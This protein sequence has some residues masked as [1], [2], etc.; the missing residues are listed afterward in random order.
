MKNEKELV[1]V[2]QS[3]PVRHEGTVAEIVAR[4]TKI[5]EAMERV[6]KVGIDYGTIPG[7]DKPSL[8]KAGAEKIANL[9]CFALIPQVDDMSTNEERR[10]RVRVEVMHQV[11]HELLG[12]GIGEASTNEE[13]YKWRRALCKEEFEGSDP[14]RRRVKWARNRRTG[15]MEQIHQIRTEPSDL[16]NTVL[17]MAKKRGVVDAI[18]TTTAAS[19]IFTQDVEDMPA[20]YIDT[21]VAPSQPAPQRK[22]P[23]PDVQMPTNPVHSNIHLI[24]GCISDYIPAKGKGPVTIKLEG[25]DDYFKTFSHEVAETLKEHGTKGDTIEIAYHVEKQG[26]WT[27]CM[28]DEVTAMQEEDQLA[29]ET[30]K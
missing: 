12:C 19:D 17:K 26:K 1:S 21:K 20:E 11:T 28:I 23:E 15:G 14:E 18:L 25:S 9:F 29:E 30:S 13:K 16:A 7:V 8:F 27:N 2:P 5:L 22:A 4:R 24:Q 3:P 6:M 10:Y